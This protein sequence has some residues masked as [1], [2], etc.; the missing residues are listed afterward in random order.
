MRRER[1]RTGWHWLARGLRGYGLPVEV[2][3][4]RQVHAVLK[5]QTNKTDA[6]DA[7]QLAGIAH[8]GFCRPVSVASE[9]SQKQRILIKARGHLVRQRQATYSAIRGFPASLGLRFPKG[10]KLLAGR[11]RA[12]LAARSDLA[13][14]KHR[15]LITGEPF[16]WPGTEVAKQ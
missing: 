1:C 2:L 4:A 15:M 13:M 8:M 14:I 16:R 9:A 12:V 6:N 3:D 5:L 11:V 10:S 7:R